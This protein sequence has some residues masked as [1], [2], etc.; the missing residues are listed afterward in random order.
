MS[1]EQIKVLTQTFFDANTD[2]V[3]R[4]KSKSKVQG[5]IENQPK[6]LHFVNS[7]TTA[8]CFAIIVCELFR[9]HKTVKTTGLT[10]GLDCFMLILVFRYL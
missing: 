4:M 5:F 1:A 10:G 7:Q 6:T 3:V 8:K 9:E 2:F